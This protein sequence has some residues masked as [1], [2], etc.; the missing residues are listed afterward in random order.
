MNVPMLTEAE[1]Q[2]V[3]PALGSA[4]EDLKRFREDHG[5]SLAE[6]QKTALGS[7]ALANTKKSQASVKRMST[8]SGITEPRSMGLRAANAESRCVRRK[9]ATVLSAEALQSNPAAQADARATAV[10]CKGKAARAAGCE[11]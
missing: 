10:L 5:V 11:R 4:I 6:A 3:A 2:T 8:P 1:W 9:R 7:S